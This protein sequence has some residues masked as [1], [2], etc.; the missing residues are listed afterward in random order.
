MS[1]RTRI[2][3]DLKAAMKAKD[4]R[5]LS[6]LRLISAAIKDRDIAARSGGDD[7]TVPDSEILSILA[8]MIRQRHESARTYE[9]AGRLE[10]AQEERDEIAVIEAYLPRQMDEAAIARA[11]EAEMETLGAGSIRDMGRVMAAL[12]ARYTG[13]MDF[14]VVGPKVKARLSGS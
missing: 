13:Q 11:I 3:D 9:E 8:R 4:G 2:S 7:Q 5:R 14:S 10:L 6:A 1:L 12:K